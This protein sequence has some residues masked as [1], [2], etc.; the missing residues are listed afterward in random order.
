MAILYIRRREQPFS[1]SAFWTIKAHS[2]P[3]DPCH[4]GILGRGPTRQMW[5]DE[6]GSTTTCRMLTTGAASARGYRQKV[7]TSS[8]FL[9]SRSRQCLGRSVWS[10]WYC[11]H[12]LSGYR[13]HAAVR[14]QL[15]V[16]CK[17]TQGQGQG[18]RGY[19]MGAE[20]GCQPGLDRC[21]P[22]RPVPQ[23]TTGW[24]N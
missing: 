22:G 7:A 14:V 5:D 18:G 11:I 24:P 6:A 8:P 10:L 9:G 15:M 23:T 13:T 19:C 12:L 20:E 4:S 3:R 2:P 17:A 16:C 1:R 21:G